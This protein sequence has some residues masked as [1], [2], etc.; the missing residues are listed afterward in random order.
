MKVQATATAVFGDRTRKPGTVDLKAYGTRE[1]ISRD[2]TIDVGGTDDLSDDAKERLRTHLWKECER[3]A[4]IAAVDV[5]DQIIMR[6]EQERIRQAPKDRPAVVVA[7]GVKDPEIGV[8]VL[9]GSWKV[10]AGPKA[11]TVSAPKA[12]GQS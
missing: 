11:R 6:E 3:I 2:V 8:Q 1:P 5:R 10:G 9:R 12:G 7:A 4:Q